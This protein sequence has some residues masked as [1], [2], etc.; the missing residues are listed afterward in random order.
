MDATSPL[1]RTLQSFFPWMQPS[2]LEEKSKTVQHYCEENRIRI[3]F[4]G[5]YPEPLKQI[6]LPPS[7]IYVRGELAALHGHRLIGFVGTRRPSPYGLRAAHFFAREM[8]NYHMTLVSGLARGVDAVGHQCSV[9]RQAA[10]VAVLGHGL[11]R[12]YPSEH[13][14]LA[15]DI[16]AH[17]GA[18]VSEFPPGVAPKPENFPRRN[19]ILSGLCLGTLVIE[20]SERSGSR[21]TAR[22]ALDQNRDVFVV[23]GQFFEEGFRGS[24]WLLQQGAKVVFGAEGIA[25]EYGWVKSAEDNYAVDALSRNLF[26]LSR[27]Q[28]IISVEDLQTCFGGDAATARKVMEQAVEKGWLVETA[29][30]R[31]LFVTK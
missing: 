30:Q 27:T 26:E 28:S 16:V 29:P 25:E 21:I 8:L 20:A 24:H 18:L 15:A 5:D 13:S 23:P 31:F 4:P 22:H 9:E 1:A 12:I 19:R 17:G 11:D 14:L 10:T 2:A 3:L 6:A 7:A